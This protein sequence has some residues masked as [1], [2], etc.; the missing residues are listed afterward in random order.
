[1]G[2]NKSAPIEE[3]TIATHIIEATCKCILKGEKKRTERPIAR[4][5]ALARIGRERLDK[6]ES[7]DSVLFN[8]CFRK[9]IRSS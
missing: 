3:M 2:I 9:L 5:K 1:M 8:P 7:T 4:P 6:A